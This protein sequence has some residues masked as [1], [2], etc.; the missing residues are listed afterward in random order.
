MEITPTLPLQLKEGHTVLI[1]VV[2]NKISGEDRISEVGRASKVIQE[3]INSLEDMLMPLNALYEA[4]YNKLS[5]FIS[6]DNEITIEFGLKLSVSGDV[7][8]ASVS[9]EANFKITMKI[10]SKK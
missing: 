6:D 9:S 5:G 7:I 2:N 1:E 8:I 4:I 3:T 10:G